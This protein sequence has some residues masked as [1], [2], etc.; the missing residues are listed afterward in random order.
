MSKNENKSLNGK[1]IGIFGKGG[2]G[3]STVTALLAKKLSQEGYPVCV[4]DADSTN[5]GLPQALGME[6]PSKTL[7]DYYGGMVFSGG[8][9]TCPVDD[10]TPLEN[11]AIS[12]DDLPPQYYTQSENGLTLLTAGK[13]GD[14][15][16]GA[17][18]DG[19]VAKIARDL[20]VHRQNAEPVTLIDFKAGFE[21]TARGA[22]TG[23]DWVLMVIDPTSA[24]LQMAVNM[25]DMVEKI[26]K[27]ELPAT[28][29]LENAGMVALANKIFKEAKINDIFFVL[30]KIPDPEVE[31]YLREKLKENDIEP[32][33]VVRQDPS[34][35]MAWLKGKPIAKEKTLQ[36][37]E[38]ILDK[39]EEAADGRA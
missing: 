12:L 5:V 15:G 21:D 8:A 10:P 14:L 28:A 6:Q 25:R 36:D 23:L 3:K 27:D 17:G 19:P 29:H 34:I 1:R 7:L 33:A 13:I 31:S 37:V 11:A 18:C 26:K 32:I 20:I 2:S 39:L 38:Y 30:N 9:V 24:S 22:V 4:L 35:P 16:P